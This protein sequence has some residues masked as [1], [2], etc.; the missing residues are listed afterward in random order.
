MLWLNSIF[1]LPVFFVF[2]DTITECQ[3]Q[4]ACDAVALKLE[5]LIVWDN[6]TLMDC[7]DDGDS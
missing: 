1:S 4:V 6:V 7:D 3:R 5:R 2:S